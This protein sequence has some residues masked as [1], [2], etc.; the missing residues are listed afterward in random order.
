M[1]ATLSADMIPRPHR[2]LQKIPVCFGSRISRCFQ[3]AVWGNA[4]QQNVYPER[5]RNLSLSQIEFPIWGFPKLGV[6]FKMVGF[7]QGK[8]HL[9]MDDLGVPL[10]QETLFF[11]PMKKQ[12]RLPCKYVPCN[13]SSQTY[14]TQKI[15]MK[16]ERHRKNKSAVASSHEHTSK[17]RI[18]WSAWSTPASAEDSQP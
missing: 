7:C 17:F 6:P 14:E 12:G 15:S 1:D 18:S 13:Q 4:T 3:L 9:E 2:M 11:L 10:F 5:F 8:S 16:H